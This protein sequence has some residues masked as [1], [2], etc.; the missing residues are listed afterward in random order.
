VNLGLGVQGSGITSSTMSEFISAQFCR[1]TLDYFLLSVG[2]RNC[3]V[4][5]CLTCIENL[6]ICADA[7]HIKSEEQQQILAED[8]GVESS[9]TT[10]ANKQT[11]EDDTKIPYS[12]YQAFAHVLEP[13]FFSFANV[14]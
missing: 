3:N 9:A 14:C 1:K 4:C 8:V 10:G 2:Q 13:S 12:V 7:G 5:S 11:S 6:P